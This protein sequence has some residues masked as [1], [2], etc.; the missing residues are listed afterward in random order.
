VLHYLRL[1]IWPDALCLDYGWPLAA[2]LADVWP[3]VAAVGAL[4][5]LTAWGVIARS[6]AAYPAAWF[7]IVLAPT[8]SFI[9]LA[10]VAEEHRMYLPLAG[11]LALIV[12][13]AHWAARRFAARGSWLT[14]RNKEKGTRNKPDE[15][16]AR[17]LLANRSVVPSP[18]SPLLAALCVL[19]AVGF[20][21]L[22]WRRN[23]DY[24]GEF[25]I[26]QDTALKC[27]RNPR[28]HSNL[29][30]LLTRG[31]RAA[32]G[33]AAARLALALK[34]DYEDALNNL[35]YALLESGRADAALAP[36]REALDR[37]PAFALAHANLGIALGRLGR[38]AEAE[39]HLRK[40]VA[41]KP[42]YAEGWCNL[43]VAVQLAGRTEEAAQFYRKALRLKPNYAKAH[44]SLGNAL[45]ALG[46]GREALG[47]LQEAVRLQPDYVEAHYA[48]ARAAFKAGELELA[49]THLRRVL[50]LRPGLTAAREELA[51]VE[52]ALAGR[53]RP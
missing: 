5:L 31:G 29:S 6:S 7:F 46:R 17:T 26:W 34:P 11:V 8:S 22:T 15:E 37:E 14:A 30:A 20:G 24:R 48:L 2:R 19:L 16:T 47:E 51:R 28:A 35:G 33:E 38:Y 39:E 42:G 53:Q 21:L 12:V 27:P 52:A 1:A 25:N 43:G 13:G 4:A 41:L 18:Q 44:G 40:A 32:E 23:A 3:S 50:E 10:D 9:P 49:R 45:A 36:L